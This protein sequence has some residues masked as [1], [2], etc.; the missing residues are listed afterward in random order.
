[1][2]D[3]DTSVDSTAHAVGIRKG[4][5]RAAPLAERPTRKADDATGINL[6]Q[7][8]PIDPRMPQLPPA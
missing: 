6:S 4:E 5:S 3:Q 7:R 1:M 2:T 8:G